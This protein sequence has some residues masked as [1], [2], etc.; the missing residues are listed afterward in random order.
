MGLITK[1]FGNSS[2]SRK[3][4]LSPE[5]ARL[6]ALALAAGGVAAGSDLPSYINRASTHMGM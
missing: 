2:D 6:A 4:E 3:E 1:I 5:D